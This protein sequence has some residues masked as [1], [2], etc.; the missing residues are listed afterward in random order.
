MI[1]P[2]NQRT[3]IFGDEGTVVFPRRFSPSITA[4]FAASTHTTQ[5]IS[6]AQL[7]AEA[8]SINN[9]RTT[10]APAP[11]FVQTIIAKGVIR[12]RAVDSGVGFRILPLCSV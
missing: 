5:E 12:L 9:A 6:N 11:I 7:K 10:P 1:Q 2:G 8:G 3:Q 4:K